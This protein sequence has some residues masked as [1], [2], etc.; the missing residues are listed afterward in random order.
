MHNLLV[1]ISGSTCTFSPEIGFIKGDAAIKSVVK[2]KM[3]NC[4]YGSQISFYCLVCPDELLFIITFHP[5]IFLCDNY[6]NIK[7]L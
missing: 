6:Q 5:D 7:P 3:R 1:I 2:I 4:L